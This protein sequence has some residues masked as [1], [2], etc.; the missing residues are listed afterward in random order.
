MRTVSSTDKI[1]FGINIEKAI[2]KTRDHLEGRDGDRGVIGNMGILTIQ[3]FMYREKGHI[4]CLLTA[5]RSAT[6]HDRLTS[7][8]M[9]CHQGVQ[10]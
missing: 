8:L 3:L 6:K 1:G 4:L 2:P 9:R 10:E 7:K 5:S